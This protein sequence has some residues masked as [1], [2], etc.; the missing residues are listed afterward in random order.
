MVCIFYICSV[1]LHPCIAILYI[2]NTSKAG[3]LKSWYCPIIFKYF[4]QQSKQEP[5]VCFYAS[6]REEHDAIKHFSLAF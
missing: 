4:A 6:R 3:D 1:H 2:D 5:L